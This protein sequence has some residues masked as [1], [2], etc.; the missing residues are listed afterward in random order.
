M[1]WNRRR[2]AA[3]R[4]RTVEECVRRKLEIVLDQRTLVDELEGTAFE[5]AQEMTVTE[6]ETVGLAE[7][8]LKRDSFTVEEE[9][10][11]IEPILYGRLYPRRFR[12]YGPNGES[13]YAEHDLSAWPELLRFIE[14]VEELRKAC[15]ALLFKRK[16]LDPQQLS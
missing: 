10:L 6:A 14:N 12:K 11:L 15:L 4:G 13:I 8:L 16:G 9:A 2:A 3:S 7:R 5:I 1:R